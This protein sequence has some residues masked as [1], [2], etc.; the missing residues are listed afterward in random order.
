[1]SIYPDKKDGLV[2]GRWRVE[3]GQVRLQAINAPDI[4]TQSGIA[5]CPSRGGQACPD[6]AEVFRCHTNHQEWRST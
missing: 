1:M 2:T 3:V 5:R 6:E 4:G